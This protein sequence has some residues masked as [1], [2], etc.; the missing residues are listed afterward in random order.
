M[1]VRACW[2][3]LS[4]SIVLLPEGEGEGFVSRGYVTLLLQLDLHQCL[5]PGG[6]QPLWSTPRPAKES[7]CGD[8]SFRN[9]ISGTSDLHENEAYR[10]ISDIYQTFPICS[11][12]VHRRLPPSQL[13]SL[14]YGFA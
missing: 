4:I 11:S 14:C 5:L 7:V 1:S 9:G 2:V 3:L 12:P 10:T 13:L 6:T 8:G